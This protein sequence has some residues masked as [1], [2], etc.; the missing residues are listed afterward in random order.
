ML[1]ITSVDVPDFGFRVTVKIR[2]CIDAAVWYK[3]FKCFEIVIY[4]FLTAIIPHLRIWCQPDAV[5]TW[6]HQFQRNPKEIV[7]LK[8]FY[9]LQ[10]LAVYDYG[11]NME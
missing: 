6:F 4:N 5:Y 10:Q 2:K 7:S 3:I 9:N 1:V 11:Y 8:Y